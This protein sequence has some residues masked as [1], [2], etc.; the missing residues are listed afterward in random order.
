MNKTI[1]FIVYGVIT[2]ICI[3]AI[4]A[5]VYV[6][7]FKKQTIGNLTN[8]TNQTNTS[9]EDP[10]V[11]TKNSFLDLFKNYFVSS[12]YKATNIEKMYQ[13]KELVFEELTY[14]EK[15]DNVYDLELHVPV[16]N[17]KSDLA[18][19]Y[20]KTTQSIF[21]DKANKIIENTSSDKYTVY[22]VS[23]TSYI[24]NDILSLAIMANLKEGDKPQRLMIQTYNYNLM[25]EEEVTINDIITLRGLDARV[26]D[27]KIADEVKKA[28]DDALGVSASGYEIYT[29][30][31]TSDMYKTQ[32]VSIFIQGP[33]G[34]LYI[35]YPYG[36]KENTSAI[37]VIQ[38]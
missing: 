31:L 19:K 36:N 2:V 1:R 27:K 4:F 34:E 11:Q 37:D 33:N 28:N 23:F 38:I 16:I 18:T 13:D 3:L 10:I 17:I 12:N 8:N 30:D 7:V 29:R 25:T 9:T 14:K 24:N 5:G 6:L 35:I 15:K 22:S 20:N 26:I 32:N 21:L